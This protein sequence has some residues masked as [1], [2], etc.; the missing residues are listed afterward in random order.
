[1]LGGMSARL[2]LCS[3][4]VSSHVTIAS[5]LETARRLAKSDYQGWTYGTDPA[6]QE[7]DAS[8][9]MAAVIA[10]ELGRPL[11]ET[12]KEKLRTPAFAQV[13][14]D[15]MLVA[16]RVPPFNVNPGDLVH[17]WQTDDSGTRTSL[18]AV[19]SQVTDAGARLY[20]ADE[21]AD[22]IGEGT[23]PINF[24]GAEEQATLVRLKNNLPSRQ[25]TTR[26]GTVWLPKA[27]AAASGEAA[28]SLIWKL[29]AKR[30]GMYDLQVHCSPGDDSR[31]FEVRLLDQTLNASSSDS[32]PQ[33]LRVYLPKSGTYPI[34]IAWAEEAVAPSIVALSLTP[35][36]EGREDLKE[37]D[38]GKVILHSRDATVRGQMLRYEPNPK[39]L[40]LGFWANPNDR[41]EWLFAIDEPGTF[42]VE[43]DQGC[44]KGQGGSQ[45][46]VAYG[47]EELAFEVEDT[48]H[49]QN[50]ITRTLGTFT[51]A[52]AGEHRVTVGA[53]GKA[54]GAVMDVREIR[55]LRQKE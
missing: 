29:A 55:L 1:M 27:R 10:E 16:I 21:T 25:Q 4:I 11:T 33:S 19:I 8:S 31:P 22:G 46:F 54:K 51:F 48:G 30:W 38:E 20:G 12:E 44:G 50:F 3:L 5:P 42:S 23:T 35:A 28:T 26:D 53:H 40:C 17:Y 6:A 13:L 39:K 41:A 37:D 43:I 34:T 24:A 18:T 36:P 14:V 49:F 9:F 15:E 7:V 45:A 47:D 32:P 52:S 2:L